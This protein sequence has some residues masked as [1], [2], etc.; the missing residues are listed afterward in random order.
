MHSN[1]YFIFIYKMSLVE[2]GY[3]T[4]SFCCPSWKTNTYDEN[5]DVG[6][7][8]DR[9]ERYGW[10]K[11]LSTILQLYHGGMYYLVLDT[12]I[13]KEN[14]WYWHRSTQREPP[15]LTPE[16][17]ERTTDIDTGLPRENH[18]H[19]H[20]STQREPPVLTSDNPERTTGIDTGL[21]REDHRHWHWIT[22]R[23]PRAFRKTLANHHIKLYWIHLAYR[24]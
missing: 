18:R 15:A 12:R 2:T 7:N 20:R 4:W 10:L 17:P 3:W 1:R 24:H 9:K 5:C 22:Q 21:P 19:W 14:H 11:L 13:S 6:K 16:C 8:I 23:E